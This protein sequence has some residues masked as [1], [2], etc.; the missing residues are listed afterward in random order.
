M[1]K[2]ASVLG[3]RREDRCADGGGMKAKKENWVFDS[4]GGSN[5]NA[6]GWSRSKL[7]KYGE[8]AA[9]RRRR[10]SCLC[11][12]DVGKERDLYIWKTKSVE[13]YKI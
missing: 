2:E 11:A 13:D 4:G 12:D 3:K 1:E 8:R 7:V 5:F 6:C 9:T 10:R